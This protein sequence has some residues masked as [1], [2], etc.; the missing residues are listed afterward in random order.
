MKHLFACAALL[1]AATQLPAQDVAGERERLNAE[2]SAA[3]A[4]FL[5]AQRECRGKFAVNDC[6]DK[7]K[8]QHNAVI[9]DLR[10]QE[11]VLNDMERRRRSAE[12]LQSL[13]ERNSP[14]RQR[15]AEERRLRA[16]QD[17]QERGERA[18]EKLGKRAVEDAQKAQHGPRAPK[19]PKGAPQPQGRAR[20]P[21]A[22]AAPSGPTP[23]EAA[24]NRRDYEARVQQAQ[25]HKAQVQQRTASRSRPAASALPIPPH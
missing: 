22:G 15:A 16:L 9:G 14:E 7:V 4:R 6:M 11:N 5:A 12:R 20:A 18:G 21:H 10:R 2:R 1:L 24:K 13:D 19:E 23:E 25:Q 8:R 3:E 17:Q